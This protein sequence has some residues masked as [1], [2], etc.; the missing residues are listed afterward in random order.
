VTVAPPP[1]LCPRAKTADRD[2]KKINGKAGE[3]EYA[4]QRQFWRRRPACITWPLSLP[5]SD[6]Q[7]LGR[8]GDDG[9]QKKVVKSSC[10]VTRVQVDYIQCK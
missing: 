10:R 6:S 1:A 5:V 3:R 8:H 7:P 4:N 9:R 2:G